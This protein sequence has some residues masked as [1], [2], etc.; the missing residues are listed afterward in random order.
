VALPPAAGFASKDLIL[1]YAWSSDIGS[2]WLWGAGLLGVLLTSVYTFR[3]LLITFFGPMKQAPTR[4]PGLAM[5]LPLVCLAVF[6]VA[7]AFL[8]WPES[9]GGAPVVSDFLQSALPAATQRAGSAKVASAASVD[10]P[11]RRP[12]GH[13]ARVGAVPPQPGPCPT[14]GGHGRSCRPSPPLVRRL[15]L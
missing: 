7:L 13:S 5:A 11:G 4:R 14:G 8:N 1:Y 2:P 15:G 10:V 12:A 6:S 9:L 3:M